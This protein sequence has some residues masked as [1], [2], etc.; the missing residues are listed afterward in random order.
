MTI[1]FKMIVTNDTEKYR[2]ETWETKEPETVAWIKSFKDDAV[3]LDIG[4]N[5][6]IYSLLCAAIHPKSRVIAI[7]PSLNN[8]LRLLDNAYLNGFSNIT[9]FLR[10]I[11][12]HAGREVFYI[13]VNEAGASG[14]QCG[15]P[16]TN[17]QKVEVV[18]IDTL[19]NFIGPVCPNHIKIDVD[20]QEDKIIRG[21]LQTL[22]YRPVES[23][24]VEINGNREY[25][26]TELFKAGFT[27]ENEFNRMEDH[28]RV[29]R[30]KEGINCENV[31]FT[32]A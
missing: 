25:I 23:V 22:L 6:G 21:G 12:D 16:I 4:A 26:Y 14:G 8:A 18:T 19:D 9:L 20:G 7:E 17:A 10:G 13:P 28:S 32:R 29:R 31:I 3:F 24:L 2:Q 1:P 30:V 11:S 5:I 15:Q 27:D